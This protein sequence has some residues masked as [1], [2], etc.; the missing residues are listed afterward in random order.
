MDIFTQDDCR[1]TYI[2]TTHGE[3]FG[4]ERKLHVH[5]FRRGHNRVYDFEGWQ[6]TPSMRAP[7]CG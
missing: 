5:R 4:D 2:K 7:T 6:G 1:R 3:I